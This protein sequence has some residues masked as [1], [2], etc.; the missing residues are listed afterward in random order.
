MKYVFTRYGHKRSVLHFSVSIFLCMDVYII[1][2]FLHVLGIQKQWK[3]E[4]CESFPNVDQEHKQ[5]SACDVSMK[6]CGSRENGRQ[7]RNSLDN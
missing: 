1:I 4:V 3:K 7:Y 6:F 2:L 5:L